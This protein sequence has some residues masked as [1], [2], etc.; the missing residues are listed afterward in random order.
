M[1][2]FVI[3]TENGKR[4]YGSYLKELFRNAFENARR[5]ADVHNYVDVIVVKTTVTM[6]DYP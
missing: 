1:P 2:N 4:K 6:N 5:N 3:Q